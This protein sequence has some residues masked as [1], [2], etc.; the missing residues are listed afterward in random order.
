[1]RQGDQ[2]Q[3]HQNA[4]GEVKRIF[5]P[6]QIKQEMARR[7]EGGV[8]GPQLGLGGMVV[9][10]RRVDER[11]PA[12]QRTRPPMPPAQTATHQH[13]EKYNR[14]DEKNKKEPGVSHVP[15]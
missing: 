6:G 12:D 2:K 7:G 1:M 3:A 15:L 5:L 11:Q 8:E 14:N 9:P 13:K 4:L 10:R